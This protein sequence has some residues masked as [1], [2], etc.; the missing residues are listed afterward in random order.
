M[1][2]VKNKCTK[3]SL[4]VLGDYWTLSIIQALNNGEKRFC[5][6]ERELPEINPTT[7]TNRLK[8][9][10]EEKLVKR[11]TE[12]LDK[13]SVVYSLTEKGTGIVPILQEIQKFADRYL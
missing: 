12:T 10:E 1:E 6:L 11:Q 5:Q 9:L 3:K 2:D 8:K 7:L 13:V 4:K